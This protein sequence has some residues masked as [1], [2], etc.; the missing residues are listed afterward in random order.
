MSFD[1]LQINTDVN[2]RRIKQWHSWRIPEKPLSNLGWHTDKPDAVLMVFFGP[3]RRMLGS[4]F[5]SG[6]GRFLPHPLHLT[7]ITSFWIGEKIARAKESIKRKDRKENGTSYL[8]HDNK[9]CFCMSSS[10]ETRK[11]NRSVKTNSVRTRRNYTLT[12]CMAEERKLSNSSNYV[13]TKDKNNAAR[14]ATYKIILK[15]VDYV[16]KRTESYRCSSKIIICH[17]PKTWLELICC[18]YVCHNGEDVRHITFQ[19]YLYVNIKHD[20]VLLF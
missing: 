1:F 14:D 17:Q 10:E 6:H 13:I 7:I 5:W 12:V 3:Y 2:D 20:T 16:I 19:Q 9:T 8:L 15:P 18:I 4:Y 11:I